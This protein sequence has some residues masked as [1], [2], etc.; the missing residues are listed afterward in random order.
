MNVAITGDSSPGDAQRELARGEWRVG[1]DNIKFPVL[2]NKLKPQIEIGEADAV[3][4]PDDRRQR[5]E[6]NDGEWIGIFIVGNEWGDNVGWTK[7]FSE[8]YA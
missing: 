2:Q 8:P 4:R 7:L 1:M 3:R 5:Q 6:P